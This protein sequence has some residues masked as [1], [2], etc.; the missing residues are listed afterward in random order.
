MGNEVSPKK[1]FGLHERWFWNLNVI[2]HK[3][4][5]LD[6]PTNIYIVLAYTVQTQQLQDLKS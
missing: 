1:R 2:S 6:A 4:T 5:D 3:S